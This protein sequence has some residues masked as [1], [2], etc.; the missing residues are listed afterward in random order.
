MAKESKN[1]EKRCTFSSLVSSYDHLYVMNDKSKTMLSC[2]MRPHKQTR[3]DTISCCTVMW[4][5][6]FIIR[7][8]SPT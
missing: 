2:D 4:L 1:V 7:V 6:Y 5:S 3:P 8:Q